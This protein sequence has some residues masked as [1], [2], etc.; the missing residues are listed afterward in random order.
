MVRLPRV[1]LSLPQLSLP[2]V[3]RVRL[4]AI[5][6]LPFAILLVGAAAWY[7]FAFAGFS[8]K[9]SVMDDTTGAPIVGARIWSPRASAQTA[10]SGS[11]A[12]DGVKP[13]DVVGVD[14][15]GYHA[16]RMRVSNPF[17]PLTAH[18]HPIAVDISTTDAD[19]GQPVPALLDGGVGART[20]GPGWLEVSGVRPGQTFRL[21]ANGY[22]P[23]ETTFTGQDTLRVALQPRLNGQITDAAT[24][25]PIAHARVIFASTLIQ[26]D[27]DGT[28]DLKHRPT[29]GQLTVLA[30]GYRAARVDLATQPS[31]DV[32]LQ[33][34]VV[35]GMYMTFFAIGGDD[36]RQQMYQLLDST[37]I[38]AVVID[39]KGDYGLL[40]YK[41]N[42]PLA[43]TIG[44][45]SEPTVDD[46][47]GLISTLHQHGAYVIG[48]VVV[49][50]DNMLARNGARAGLDVGV[51]DRRTGQQWVDGENLAWVDP[52]QSA[53]WDYNTAL[54]KEA[55]QHGFDEV[56]FDYI[57]FPTDPSPD[58]SIGDIV[59][60]QPM[61]EDN[62]VAALKGFLS[63]AHAAITAAGG[64]LSMDTFGYTTWWTDDG[65]IGQDLSVLA[66][67]IDYYC[68][69]VYPS[70]FSAGIPGQIPYPD[71]VSR[72]YDV[73]FR[74]LQ[75]VEQKLEGKNLVVRPWLQYFDDYPWAQKVRYDA[76]QI[77]AQKKAVVD[78]GSQGWMFWNAGSLYKRG[79]FAPKS[80]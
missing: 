63:R 16:A 23:A 59:Y 67:N 18:L 34:N 17:D 21:A 24:G 60:S 37:E 1:R 41:S 40:S 9:G 64:Y 52:F 25:K 22:A 69:M 27:D 78:S 54:A 51:K 73:V 20:M 19:S 56:Q 53:A 10:G 55:I 57:R 8:L 13:T 42:V 80:S 36:Y 7:H 35:R 15:P 31:L 26:A 72:P 2:R 5:S 6:P 48:R 11:F 28:Y 71:V 50:K 49:F 75:N 74:S 38:N 62:R 32:K 58:D 70:T 77:E 65:G 29:S 66:D 44:A 39:V 68:P 3:P 45:D 79:G 76:P 12:L 46:I 33:P 43:N 30:P 47:D 14:A 4:P 61:S